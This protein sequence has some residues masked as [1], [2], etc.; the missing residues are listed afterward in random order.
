MMRNITPITYQ[1]QIS[2]LLV[3]VHSSF[4]KIRY[5]CRIVTTVNPEKVAQDACLGNWV[6]GWGGFSG[7][8]VGRVVGGFG[9]CFGFRN[10][11]MGDGG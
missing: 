1:T 7:H 6:W 10:L 5:F 9:R 11:G 8:G 3:Y 4:S 2:T